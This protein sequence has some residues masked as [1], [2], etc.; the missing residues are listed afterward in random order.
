MLKNLLTI[1]LIGFICLSTTNL[2][3]QTT[4]NS[5][6]F[7]GTPAIGWTG[8]NVVGPTDVWGFTGGIALMN[9]FNSSGTEADGG[10]DE[11]WLV[12]PSMTLNNS[13]VN[14]LSF[15]Y[16]ERFTGPDLQLY[17]TTNYTG[18]PSTTTWML[19][20]TLAD[21][22]T[23]ATA[24]A[25]QNYSSNTILAS[26]NGSV[27][28]AFKYTTSGTAT[29]NNA[30]EWAID[31]ILV[32]SQAPV[33]CNTPITQTASLGATPSATSANIS[34]VKGDGTN[35]LVLINT[36]DVFTDPSDGTAYTANTV[37]GGSGQQVVYNGANT[38]VS[39]TGLTN[40]TT[41]YVV[42]YN[43]NN[44][45][46]PSAVDYVI[47]APPTADFATSSPSTG[48]TGEP[49]GYYDAANGLT[50]TAKQSA[51]RTIISAGYIDRGYLG[52]WTT[53]TTTDILPGSTNKIWCIY[54][55]INGVSTC[56]ANALTL[57]DQD[58][59]SGGT[60]PCDKYN[61]EHTIP[62]SWFNE[63][64]PMVSD[65]FH[66]LPT[67]KKIN[68]V[69]GNQPYGETNGPVV[70]DGNGTKYGVSSDPG[71]PSSIEVM[72]PTDEFKGD[73]ARIHLYMSTRYGTLAGK[74]N[75][76]ESNFVMD[77][78]NYPTY[79]VPYLKMLLRWHNADP[80]SQKEIDRNNAVYARQRNRNP[81]VDHPEYVAQVWNNGCAGLSAL[82]VTLRTF[83]AA[84]RNNISYLDWRV[85]EEK[86]LS[87]YEVQRSID[88]K[89]FTKIGLI[90][91][92]NAHDYRFEDPMNTPLSNRYYYRLKMI[93]LDGSYDYSKV[94]SIEITTKKYFFTLFPNPASKEVKLKFGEN[95]NST[96][97]VNV[98]DM[99]G[100]VWLQQNFTNTTELNTLNI[101][102][103][104]MGNYI[105]QS[106]V[107]GLVSY[108][109]LV[110]TE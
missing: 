27:V 37:Y 62:Q 110:V 58:A 85:E 65:A 99:L 46:L 80:V 53:Y 30:E 28:L 14:T 96:V 38:S 87:H 7:S 24:G 6:N 42:A 67:D 109:R 51:L 61:R 73:I 69:H 17:Y 32:Q 54:T 19:L 81:Y 23:T 49:A 78:T 104:P 63:S 82:P 66:V 60:A 74:A 26:L 77:D 93:D 102:S 83:E 88:G 71:V 68:N 2:D 70:A 50:C 36:A 15:K 34:W 35:T 5:E 106:S 40:N 31:D 64:S 29:V 101:N 79:K 39:V 22:N 4:I 59:G 48:P 13:V 3:A 56:G 52:L 84:F 21:Y 10:P 92:A 89:T 94:V 16:R 91:S 105:V 12:S 98:T 9:G 103:L 76:S 33:V 1:F 108:Q 107:N 41:Y 25:F 75:T 95:I 90:K 47:T 44:C 8:V 86:E 72:E 45:G 43:F 20:T 57:S 100:K 97:K 11:D 55:T 18:N